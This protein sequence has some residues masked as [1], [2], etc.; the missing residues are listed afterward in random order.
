MNYFNY[1]QDEFI[2]VD[3]GKILRVDINPQKACIFNCVMCNHKKTMYMGEW[4]DFG[5]V[6]DSLK[7]L[8]E[9]IVQENPEL[10]EVYGQGDVLTN[11][12]LGA[13]IDC[14]HN[15]GLPVRILT[16]SYLVGIGEH[17][18]LASMCEEVVAAIG[19][20]N[21]ADFKKIHRPLE[22]MDLTAAK[23]IESLVTFSKQYK[24]K[25]KL[26]IFLLKGYNDSDEKVKELKSVIDR[27]N[28]DSL[29]VATTQ[30]LSISDERVEEII[31]VLNT[32]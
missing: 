30:K 16:N 13:V 11:T 10:V 26:R 28:Y 25:L 8:G 29:W 6:E 2:K 5:P 1:K 12:N 18:R 14:I 3:E 21:E 24:G 31:E 15:H 4:H 17:M 20:T 19:L 7:Y 22:E 32:K 23:Q 27:V 9:K